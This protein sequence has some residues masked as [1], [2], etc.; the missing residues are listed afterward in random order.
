MAGWFKKKTTP[1][2]GR[3]AEGEY[4]DVAS[5]SDSEVNPMNDKAEQ[6]RKT[7]W[8]ARWRA[9]GKSR[10][11]ATLQDGFTELVGLTRSIR[12][13][14]EQQA[15]T[16]QTLVNMM[17]HIPGAVE[18]LKHVGK[19]TQQQTET[20]GLL[21]KQLE[22]AARNED[23]MVQSMHQFNK[24]LTLMDDLS[25]RT[26]QTVVSMADRTR[27]SE[28]LL[29]AVLQRSERRLTY[30]IIGLMVLTLTVLGV[31]LYVGFGPREPQPPAPVTDPAR[32]D[33]EPQPL[34][35]LPTIADIEREDEDVVVADEW[36]DEPDPA[37]YPADEAADDV[38]AESITEP[39]TE[40]DEMGPLEDDSLIGDEDKDPTADP[41]DDV[42]AVDPAA[43]EHLT[44]AEDGVDDAEPAAA[45]EQEPV[46]EP[47]EAFDEETD[48]SLDSDAPDDT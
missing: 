11:M 17:E 44:D 18:G 21:K 48:G 4:I 38:H 7:G 25:K 12:E 26:S 5:T 42:E 30:M 47:V 10:Q 31:G 27:D 45:A 46:D 29:R 3:D 13:H 36:L 2:R 33:V 35:P 43:D 34:P 41:V 23:H 22:A 37:T 40:L 14:M 6:P 24:T 19:A 28:E 15:K 1:P 20:L 32:L 9:P 39:P 8:L 16:Q